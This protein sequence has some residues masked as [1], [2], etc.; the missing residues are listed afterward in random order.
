MPGTERIHPDPQPAHLQAAVYADGLHG[1]HP[2]WPYDYRAWETLAHAALPAT[3]WNYVHGSAGAGATDDANTAAFARVGLVPR[4]LVRVEMPDLKTTVFGETF[5]YP[6]ALA[7]IG[8]HSIFHRDKEPAVARAAA[9]LGITYTMSTAASTSIEAAAAASGAGPRWYQLYWPAPEHNAITLSLLAR[10]RA[11]GFAALVVTLDTYI[12]GWRPGDLGAGY[13]P[14][15]VP[16]RTG[17][18]IGLTDP[19]WGKEWAGAHGGR[20]PG[21]EGE[22]GESSPAW[23]RIVFPGA[24]H[25]WEDLAFLR[26]H[27]DGPIVLKGIQTVAD[28]RRA[29]AAKMDGIVVSNHG[30]RQVDGSVPSLECLAPIVKAVG[31]EIEVLFDSGVRSGADVV[32]ALALGAKMV[33]VGRPYIYGLAMGGE[34]GVKHVLGAILADVDLTMQLSGYASVRQLQA[35]AG[36]GQEGEEAFVRRIGV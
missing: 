25:S 28:A 20:E 24:S 18:E 23:A 21:E 17:V 31:Q 36:E 22:L 12:L 30:G 32:K 16:D 9:A 6:V 15:L 29:V 8:V 4:R 27:W 7:P 5:D 26:E 19:V 2:R 10:A 13:N 35:A 34:A 1:T 14:F 33:F 3:A 11:A